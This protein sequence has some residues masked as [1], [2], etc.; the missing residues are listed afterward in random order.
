MFRAIP[1]ILQFS[2]VRKRFRD[3]CLH[4][5]EL[6]GAF[7]GP[8]RAMQLRCAMRFE[9]TPKSLA[10]PKKQA[11]VSDAETPE[12]ALKSQEKAHKSSCE[13]LVIL[14]CDAK[15]WRCESPAIQTLVAVWPVMNAKSLAIQ[16]KRCE[17]RSWCM[18]TVN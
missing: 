13:S 9:S 11:F 1:Q 10:M 7:D 3:C 12:L 15:H 4:S 14:A 17:P 6:V 5:F 16:V 2:C 18:L 8:N